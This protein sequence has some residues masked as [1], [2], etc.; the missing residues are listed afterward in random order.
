M[1]RQGI[2]GA[3]DQLLDNELVETARHH[4]DAQ[5]RP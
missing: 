3:R 4:S 1:A 5:T 2:A